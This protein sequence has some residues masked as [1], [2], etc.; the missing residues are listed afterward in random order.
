[1]N[2]AVDGP[3]ALMGLSDGRPHLRNVGHIGSQRQH[4]GPGSFQCQQLLQF[5]AHGLGLI[6]RGSKYLPA[7]AIRNGTAS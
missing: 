2:H 3:E 6:V 4:L 1:M 7:A 5:L